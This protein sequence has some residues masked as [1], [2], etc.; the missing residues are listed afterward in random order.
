MQETMKKLNR[1]NPGVSTRIL[2]TEVGKLWKLKGNTTTPDDTNFEM[3][4]E[5]DDSEADE[6]RMP[7]PELLP[8]KTRKRKTVSVAAP[9][10][11]KKKNM[12]AAKLGV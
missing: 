2:M 11:G 7:S 8:S 10:R 5:E 6:E 9:S 4:D 1:Q 3:A 12:A